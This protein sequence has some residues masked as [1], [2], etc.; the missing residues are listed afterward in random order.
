M[1]L[2]PKTFIHVVGSEKGRGGGGGSDP[3]FSRYFTRIP[4]PNLPS[5]L[6]RLVVFFLNPAFVPRQRFPNLVQ[7]PEPGNTFPDPVLQWYGYSRV[8]R[9]PIPKTLVIWASPSL[10]NLA[11]WVKVRVTGDAHITRVLGMGKPKTRGPPYQCDTGDLRYYEN[12]LW[13]NEASSLACKNLLFRRV[14]IIITHGIQSISMEKSI[15][16]PDSPYTSKN[17]KCIFYEHCKCRQFT[18]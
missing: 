6:S 7:I 14:L 5:S 3:A 13:S 17:R 18:K 9:I 12:G 15:I 11:I 1:N 8:L 10:I 2:C 4:R 16:F